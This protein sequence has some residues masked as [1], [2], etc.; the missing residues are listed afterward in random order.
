MH[1]EK[2]TIAILGDGCPLGLRLNIHILLCTTKGIPEATSTVVYILYLYIY[3]IIHVPSDSMVTQVGL[4]GI[5]STWPLARLPESF[6][7][8]R[9]PYAKNEQKHI[10][11]LLWIGRCRKDFSWPSQDPREPQTHGHDRWTPCEDR[12]NAPFPREML[13]YNNI[14]KRINI[15][16]H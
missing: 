11:V 13:Y 9:E 12:S 8:T 3:I 10:R 2:G 15:H 14:M 5:R 4:S 6:F 1:T 16:S 7:V